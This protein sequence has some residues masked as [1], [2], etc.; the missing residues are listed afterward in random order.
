M[1]RVLS[2]DVLRMSIFYILRI[3]L[4]KHLL[5]NIFFFT[6]IKNELYK[7]AIWLFS[8]IQL[9]ANYWKTVQNLPLFYDLLYIY[10]NY[11][12]GYT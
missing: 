12:L 8:D 3:F 6:F 4:N 9:Q 10:V 11:Y 1:F 7:T 2:A 5:Y